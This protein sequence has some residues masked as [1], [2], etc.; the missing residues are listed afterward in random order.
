MSDLNPGNWTGQSGNFPVMNRAGF[1]GGWL[2]WILCGHRRDLKHA[3]DEIETVLRGAAGRLVLL[4][5][6]TYS[7]WLNPIEMLWR[8]FRREVTHCELFANIEA[9]IEATK[10]FFD[11]YN[12]RSD[13]VRSFIGAHPV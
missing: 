8:Q 11:G 12:K 4:Y 9:L 2:A 10:A 6:P 5:L 1:S 13:G 3:D 7:P